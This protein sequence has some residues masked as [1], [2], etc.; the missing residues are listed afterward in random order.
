MSRWWFLAAGLAIVALTFESGRREGAWM[1]IFLV[2]SISFL[3][4]EK[5]VI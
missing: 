2:L 3:A 5:G 4:K 1:L